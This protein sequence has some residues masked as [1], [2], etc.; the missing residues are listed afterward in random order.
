[1]FNSF[2]IE[3]VEGFP[4]NICD[5]CSSTLDAAC[6]FINKY[7][8][9]SKILQSGLLLVKNESVDVEFQNYSDALSEVEVEIKDIKKEP[10]A[11]FENFDDN[12]CLIDLI[13][14]LKFKLKSKELTIKK[15]KPKTSSSKNKSNKIASSLLEGDFTWTGEKW[16]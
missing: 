5:T 15:T 8:E 12:E 6:N 10:I 1:M 3:D 4:R 16:W 14:P 7:K 9:S 11:D 2:Q 13:K